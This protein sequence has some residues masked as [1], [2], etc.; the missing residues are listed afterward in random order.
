MTKWESIALATIM[1]VFFGGLTISSIFE[2]NSDVEKAKAGLEEC[3][4]SIGSYK[5]IWVKDCI[6]YTKLLKEKG[7]E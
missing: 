5:S 4:K 2:E 1:V 6:V 3:P 7:N